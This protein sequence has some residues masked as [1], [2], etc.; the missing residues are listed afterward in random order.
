[1]NIILKILSFIWNKKFYA[2]IIIIALSVGGYFVYKKVHYKSSVSYQTAT[3]E[4]GTITSSVSGSGNII[5]DEETTINPSVSGTITKLSVKSGSKV[6]KGQFLFYIYNPD[7]DIT[8]NKSYVSYLQAKQSLEDAKA[9]LLEAQNNQTTVENK[10]TST[11]EEKNLAAQKVTAAQLNVDAAS[12]NVDSALADYNAQKENAAKR[13]VTAPIAGTITTLNIKNGDELGTSS[14][15]G[16][17]SSASSSSSSSS[18]SSTS[19][20]SSAAMII[21]NLNSLKASVAV[22]EVDI[23]KISKDQKAS[24]TFN[25]IEDLTLTG[26]VE[27][28]DQTG[29]NSSGVVT[30]NVTIGLDSLDSKV[31]PQ[32]SVSATITTE[33]KQDVLVISSSAVKTSGDSRYVEIMVNGKVSQQTV[34]IG[35]SSDTQTEITSGL[36]EGDTVVTQTSTNSST[37]TTSRSNSSGGGFDFPGITGGGPG[38]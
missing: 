1:L 30:Y 11:D 23:A 20:S 26:K 17:S 8:V 2:I 16:G 33:V 22:N 9:K 37:G 4:K 27:E 15:Q 3:V 38:R 32:M 6:K 10:S 13:T 19:S 31:K 25:A 12:V 36:K 29:T 7:L 14:S 35:I 34:E 21:Q 28:I 24:L 5:V 18:T